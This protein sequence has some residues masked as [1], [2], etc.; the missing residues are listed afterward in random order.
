MAQRAQALEEALRVELVDATEL[1]GLARG[2]AVEAR[3]RALDDKLAALN[4]ADVRRI[5]SGE[6]AGRRWHGCVA[7]PLDRALR[8]Q[9]EAARA[10]A[11]GVAENVTIPLQGGSATKAIKVLVEHRGG[12][13]VALYLPSKK[14]LFGGYQMGTTFAVPGQR[15]RK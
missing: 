8:K 3:F 9:I 11:V 5:G 15:N 10:R 14:K 6:L 7:Q 4:R 2:R 1:A 12:L 13:C